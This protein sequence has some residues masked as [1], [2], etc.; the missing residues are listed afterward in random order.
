MVPTAVP[1]LVSRKVSESPRVWAA[2]VRMVL[3]KKFGETEIE[4]W[5]DRLGHEIFAGLMSR[6][7]IPFL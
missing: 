5:R 7:T 4:I 3:R 2:Q 6:C 1:G